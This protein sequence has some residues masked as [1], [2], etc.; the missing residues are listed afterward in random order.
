[1]G[2][3]RR[4]STLAVAV[5]VAALI[6]ACSAAAT[7]VPTTAPIPT[8]APTPAPT[9]TPTAAP[10]AAV[11]AAPALSPL[12]SAAG[13]PLPTSDGVAL[14]AGTYY[15]D[16]AGS[17]AGFINAQRLSFTVPTG[18]T[19]ADFAAKNRGKPG[20]VFF[21]VWV[22]T[23][24]F[25]DAC[26]WG[27]LVNA[28]TTAADLI[29]VLAAQQGR[30]ASAPSEATIGGYSATRIE[31]TVAPDLDTST[32]TDGNLRYWPGAAVD[33][34][35]PDMSS[36]LCC[37]PAGNID[38]VYALDV[39]GRRNV[40]VARFYPGSSEADKAELQSILD[41]IQ[42][43]PLPPLPSPSGSTSP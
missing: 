40:V 28:G 7:P 30:T 39:A 15:V 1:M 34:A 37:N 31:L 42:I 25:T 26:H 2:G 8:T 19:S 11:T 9:S 3:Y 10:T 23:H 14:S 6:G 4:G 16:D 13:L 22:V 24:V 32:C 29:K 35:G 12:P 33:G 27:T 5:A 41:S 21:A 43:E 36:G 38:D 18:W 20:E 17:T